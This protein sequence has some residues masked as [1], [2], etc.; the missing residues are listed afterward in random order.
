[1]LRRGLQLSAA[2]AVVSLGASLAF[3]FG[4]LFARPLENTEGCLLFEA[5]R[6]RM[7][8]ALYIDPAFGAFDYG[9]VP[10]RYYVLYPPLWA[11][12]L[13]RAPASA[14]AACGR[15][16]SLAAWYGVL[17]WIGLGAYRRQRLLGVLFVVFVGGV[18]LLTLY[19]ASA[20]PDALAVAIAAVALERVVLSKR[21]PSALLAGLFAVAAFLKPNVVGMA[22]GA[23]LSLARAPRRLL[24]LVLGFTV[25]SAAL[26]LPL[27]AVSHGALGVHIE[28]S[29]LQPMSLS[30][31]V[32]QMRTRLPFFGVPLALAFVTG[33][34]GFADPGVR[35]ATLALGAS[36]LWTLVSLAKVG[37]A[38]CYW[39][40][41][42][43]AAAVV[44]AHAPMP[45]LSARWRSVLAFAVPLQALWTGVGSFRSSVESL[46]TSHEKSRVIDSLRSGLAEGSLL[47]SDDAGLELALDGRLIDTPFQTTALV[48]AGLFPEAAWLGDVQRREIVGLV[49]S[50]DILERPLSE[51]DP[52]HDRYDV[53]M[54]QALRES[55][56]L[57]SRD[58]GY[59]VYRRR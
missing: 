22:V 4:T 13:S 46:A 54:R 56:V 38:S 8:L 7:G 31:W 41:P 48:R 3:A 39:M 17:A 2:I 40:E 12:L 24:P 10:V 27:W 55:F 42:C 25:V 45:A 53:V 1:V 29:M 57:W 20:R 37:S 28:R 11:F 14:A 9:P 21:P 52:A 19:G 16:V 32:E 15:I 26:L 47:L 23:A 49:A 44:F 35:V 43:V 50:D 59:Y 58:A 18:Y 6:I 51:V 36:V 33:A 30:L 5:S 34:A